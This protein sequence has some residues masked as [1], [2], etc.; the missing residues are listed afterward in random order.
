[1]F[2]WKSE[3]WLPGWQDGCDS[4]LG[5]G[6]KN[7]L[8]QSSLSQ[9]FQQKSFKKCE[10]LITSQRIKSK[11]QDD[12]SFQQSPC[13]YILGVDFS[14]FQGESHESNIVTISDGDRE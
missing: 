7:S 8:S 6:L 10:T 5:Q 1:M 9:V 3:S 4:S 14:S 11:E 13:T 12:E 2:G